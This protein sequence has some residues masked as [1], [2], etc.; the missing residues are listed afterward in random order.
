MI[1]LIV[2]VTLI[3]IIILTMAVMFCRDFK[4]IPKSKIAL[5]YHPHRSQKYSI[6]SNKYIY[7]DDAQMNAMVDMFIE[8]GEKRERN[9]Q[10]K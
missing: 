10:N 7:M 1:V 4:I 9:R 8:M 3:L 6:V 2:M 5:C